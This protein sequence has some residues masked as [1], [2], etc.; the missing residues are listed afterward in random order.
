MLKAKGRWDVAALVAP[1][2]DKKAHAL[3]SLRVVGAGVLVAT[4]ADSG[5]LH[6]HSLKGT[7]ARPLCPRISHAH[8]AR[9]VQGGDGLE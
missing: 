3:R 8:P 5:T 2:A 9:L 1:H 6:V 4:Y 7:K